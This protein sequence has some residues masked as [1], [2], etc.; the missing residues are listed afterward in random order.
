MF[1]F[2]ILLTNKKKMQQIG[3]KNLF[4]DFKEAKNNNKDKTIFFIHG[5]GGKKFFQK[6]P[7]EK[8]I[9][10]FLLISNK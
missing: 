8:E 4:V 7:K 1:F 6:F 10:Y 2:G 3:G 5:L 9:L